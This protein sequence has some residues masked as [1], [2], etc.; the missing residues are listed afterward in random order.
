MLAI[1]TRLS[2]EDEES[3]SIEHQISE[4]KN[5]ASDNKLECKVYNEGE[6]VSATLEIDKRPQLMQLLIDVSGK[7]IT[8]VWFRNSNRL[9]RNENTYHLF[10]AEMQKH[11]VQLYFDDK[12]F[13]YNDPSQNLMGSILS[14]INTYQAKLQSY[15]TKKTLLNNAREGK[16]SGILKYGYTK[17][18]SGVVVVDEDESEVVKKVFKMALTMGYRAIAEWLNGNN[19]HTR[20]KKLR[21]KDTKWVSQVIKNILKSRVYIGEKEYA[22][23]ILKIPAI[24]KE[25]EFNKVQEHILGRRNKSGK[26]TEHK[27]LLNGL[28]TCG[29]CGNRY[30]GRNYKTVSGEYFY[31]RC[32]SSIGKGTACGNKYIKREGLENLIW[33]DLF[34]G[35]LLRNHLIEQLSKKVEKKNYEEDIRTLNGKIGSID[36]RIKKAIDLILEGLIEKDDFKSKKLSLENEKNELKIKLVKIKEAEEFENSKKDIIRDIE[37]ELKDIR[38]SAP[39]IEKQKLI[40]S[41][42]K[43]IKIKAWDEQEIHVLKIRTHISTQPI[44]RIRAFNYSDKYKEPTKSMKINQA[45]RMTESEFLAL[46]GVY[47]ECQYL[48]DYEKKFHEIFNEM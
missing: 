27:Y 28:L 35:S 4:G 41:Y 38:H 9:S 45:R 2:K 34:R 47:P 26:R 3:S 17:D 6:G 37:E 32:T 10:I 36:N 44:A 40:K 11:D 21:G 5:F 46:N 16:F 29:K 1:Y 22:G 15:Q 23:E 12:L 39:F 25:E 33:G 24:I 13:D 43:N 7:E 20:Y 30:T 8:H 31:Y 42:V 48:I 14:S 19:I 18:E